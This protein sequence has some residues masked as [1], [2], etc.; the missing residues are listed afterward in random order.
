M[1]DVACNLCGSTG[2]RPFA[3][4]PDLQFERFDVTS[5]L[6]QCSRCGLVYQNPRLEPHELEEHYPASYELYQSPQESSRPNWLLQKAYAYGMNKRCRFVTRH[7]P[8]GRLLDVGCATGTF[9]LAMQQDHRWQVEGIEVNAAV[10]EIAQQRTGVPVS[11][12]TL[13]EAALPAASFDA[14]TMWD[15]LEHVQDARQTAAEIWRLLK[16]GGIFVIRVPNLASWDVKLFGKA[17]AGYDAPRH[18]YCFSPAT[19]SQLLDGTGFDVLEVS[20]A[21]GN[22]VTFALSACYWMTLRG[23]SKDTQQRVRRILYHPL[24]RILSAP[25]FWIPS[26]LKRGSVLVIT[27]RKPQETTAIHKEARA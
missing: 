21:I 13:E 22:Y 5:N 26:M 6:V 2:S 20:G 23:V 12:S 8:G 18:L 19:L 11:A 25:L 1:K 3:L 24:L 7:K 10:A 9:M 27:A 4:V 17:W 15:V 14:V 16:P